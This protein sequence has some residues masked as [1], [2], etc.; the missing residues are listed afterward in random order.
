MKKPGR[1]LAPVVIAGITVGFLA[2]AYKF[3]FSK[4]ESSEQTTS[5]K[6]DSEKS[7][8]DSKASN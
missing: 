5:H 6:H 4:S 2:S 1:F 3:V 7:S 8:N